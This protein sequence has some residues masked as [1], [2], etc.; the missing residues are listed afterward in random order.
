MSELLALAWERFKVIT[1]I[2]G[3]VQSY[4][5]ATLF[6]FTVVTPFG[7]GTRLFSDPL[8]QRVAEGQSRWIDRQ[9][10]PSDLDSAKRQG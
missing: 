10:T 4:L 1:S 7:V 5:I 3:D 2:I 9:T 8:R 6:Y